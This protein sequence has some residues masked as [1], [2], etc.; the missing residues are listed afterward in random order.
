[1]PRPLRIIS[2]TGIYHVMARGNRRKVIFHDSGDKQRFINI[3]LN[4]NKGGNFKIFAYCIMD[5]HY[6]LLIKEEKES[7]STIMKMI[8]CSYATYYNSKYKGVGHVFQDRYRS[9]AVNN[10]K[11][12]LGL[13]RYIHN[14]PVKAGM[15]SNCKDYPWSSYQQY[16]H[17]KKDNELLQVSF[18]LGL[19]SENP[20]NAIKRFVEFTQEEN[21]DIYLEDYCEEEEKIK[22]KEYIKEFTTANKINIDELKNNMLYNN[23]R[24]L[25]I[26]DIKATSMLSVT[27]IAEVIGISRSIVYRS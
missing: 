19:F 27:Q 15:V 18:V 12:L 8:N 21:N 11:Y 22:I 5:N 23:L 13:S 6:H 14:N 25:M 2:E 7:L 9:E 3:I 26:R 10:D 20:S 16:F 4:K 17:Y 1:M 24:N